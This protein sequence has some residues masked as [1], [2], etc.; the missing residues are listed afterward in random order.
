MLID[1]EIDAAM[2]GDK[3][4]DPR[5]KHFVPDPDAAAHGWA[6][7]H[8]GVPINHMLVMR[9]ALSKSRPD[10]VQDVFRQFRESKRAS[11]LPEG[12]LS[13]LIVSGSKPVVRFCRSLS[14]FV[15]TRS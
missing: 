3:L 12:A 11:G 8:H 7:R 6:E 15:C 9:T 5:L 13:I 10:I 4:P 1:G 2:V 14:I